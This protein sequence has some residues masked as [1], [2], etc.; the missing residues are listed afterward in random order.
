MNPQSWNMYSYVMNNPLASIDPDGLDCVHVNVDTGAY[1]GF[2]S[3]DCDNSTEEKANSGQYFDGAVNQIQLGSQGQVF[4]YSGTDENGNSS[5]VSLSAPGNAQVFNVNPYTGVMTSS[6]FGQTVNVT[7]NEIAT[8]Q[9]DP[10]TSP[11]SL[12]QA[13]VRAWQPTPRPPLPTPGDCA[14]DPDSAI[15]IHQ[16]AMQAWR[17]Q[18]N[19]PAGSSSGGDDDSGGGG[20]TGGAYLNMRNNGLKPIPQLTGPMG[21]AQGAAGANGAAMLADTFSSYAAC[22]G[23]RE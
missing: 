15:A 1:E 4:G 16:L 18:N 20:G 19:I 22:R 2:E 3:G 6:E 12:P 14:Y 10:N 11:S 17:A 9:L 23:L 7:A 21:N 13:S 5:S 8:P